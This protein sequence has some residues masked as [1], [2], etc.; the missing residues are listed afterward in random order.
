[1]RSR[2]VNFRDMEKTG[3][4]LFPQQ[5]VIIFDT[6]YTTWEGAQ[7]RAWSGPNEYKEIVQIGG[8]SIDGKTLEELDSF[9]VFVRPLKNPILSGYFTDL[10]GIMQTQIDGGGI[11]FQS[12][13]AKFFQWSRGVDLYSFGTDAQVLEE[14]CR[15][16]KID[17]PFA[18]LRFYDVREVFQK[19]GI[20]AQ[21]Y[22]SGRI[23]EAFGKTVTRRPHNALHDALT[24]VDGLRL[25]A[26]QERR[27]HS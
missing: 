26:E 19:F 10:T 15:L 20:P 25:L 2:Q 4:I 14:N 22:T 17:F 8:V 18:P 5:K 21:K 1:M 7:E 23:V 13:L 27:D 12:A 24:I 6:E 9:S 16:C 11:D 3:V